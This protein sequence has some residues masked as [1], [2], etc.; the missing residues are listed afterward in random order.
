MANTKQKKEASKPY[1]V[2]ATT[3]VRTVKKSTYKSFRLHKKIKPVQY[4]LPSSWQLF[5]RSVGTL[6]RYW[7]L[8][9]GITLIYGILSIILVKGF[10]ISVGLNE[11]KDIFNETAQ[12]AAGKV[13]VGASLLIVLFESSSTT[14]VDGGGVYQTIFLLVVSLAFIWALR[15]VYALETKKALKIRIRDAYYRGMSPLV[16]FV[17]VFLVIMIELIPFAIG[18]FL[19]STVVA[20][21]IAVEAIEKVLW[22][23]LFVSSIVLSAY[24]LISTLFALYIVALPDMTPMRA[25]RSARGIVKYRR[26][27][28]VRKLLAFILLL[29]GCLAAVMIPLILF[30]TAWAEWAFFAFGIVALAL[31]HSYMYALYRELLNE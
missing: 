21:G 28:V 11:L 30:A 7:K 9:F 26:W 4:H 22:F 17:L 13:T 31:T 8:F 6:Q 25:L 2:E 12:D 29:L 19:Y 27:V 16:P 10:N 3:A 1:K 24:L 20:N 18:S 15:Q 5:K 14:A 23:L